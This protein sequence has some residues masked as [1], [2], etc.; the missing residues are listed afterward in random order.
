MTDLHFIDSSGILFDSRQKVVANTPGAA[1]LDKASYASKLCNAG[2]VVIER[3]DQICEIT[4]HPCQLSD[5]AFIRLM[6][7]LDE[8][9]F[10]PLV[11]VVSHDDLSGNW[12]SQIS[13][14]PQRAISEISEL[15]LIVAERKNRRVMTVF[16]R[17]DDLATDHPFSNVCRLWKQFG[18]NNGAGFLEAAEKH[19]GRRFTLLRHDPANSD[20]RFEDFGGGLPEYAKSTL[21]W[22]LGRKVQ[23]HPDIWYG[24]S[25]RQ[26]YLNALAAFRIQ[27]QSVDA[28]VHWRGF[29]EAHQ[30][31]ERLTV[32]F[33][34]RGQSWILSCT[35]EDTSIDLRSGQL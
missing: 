34:A 3:N 21:S 20:F 24:R 17:V 27:L 7:W 35:L 5:E 6:E 30:H 32:P 12:T 8:Q 29:G 33:E 1:L 15:M 14:S 18:R 2:L 9:P 23:E 16:N 28:I 4:L 22:L 25:C 13:E 26:N 31:Y 10:M 11:V 19:L